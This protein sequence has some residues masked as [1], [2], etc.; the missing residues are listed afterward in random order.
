[1]SAGGSF[2]AMLGV[3]PFLWMV[4]TQYSPVL[5]AVC[6]FLTGIGQG[7]INIPSISAAYA[8]VAR[9]RLAVANTAINIA[10]RLGGP[11]T[12]TVMAIVMSLVQTS[13]H[14]A[15]VDPHSFMAPFALL[16]G[17]NLLVFAAACRLPMWIHQPQAD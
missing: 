5:A 14:Q 7:T 8:S 16:I 4:Y 11:V 15:A 10:Q 3:L 9:D 1:V 17:V 2:L 13:A 12:V 6:L